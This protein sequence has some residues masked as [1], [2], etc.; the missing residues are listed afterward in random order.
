MKSSQILKIEL[1]NSIAFNGEK[2]VPVKI[3]GLR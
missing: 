2:P 3:L 1:K